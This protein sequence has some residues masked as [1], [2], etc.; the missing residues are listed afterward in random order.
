MISATNQQKVS[1]NV[2]IKQQIPFK[3]ASKLS[4]EVSKT[5]MGGVQQMLP[6]KL[7]QDE[8][9][10]RTSTSGYQRL[11]SD[12]SFSPPSGDTVSKSYDRGV[13]RI[14]LQQDDFYFIDFPKWYQPQIN[15]ICIFHKVKVS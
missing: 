11:G 13:D 10:R 15:L 9:V 8:K 6:L 14:R 1:Q 7:S 4:G 5:G 3:L 12:N 2:H